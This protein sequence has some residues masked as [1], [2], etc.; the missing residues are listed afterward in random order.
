VVDL[1]EA[2]VRSANTAFAELILITGTEP[3][4]IETGSQTSVPALLDAII[5]RVP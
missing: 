4:L 1:R 5:E 2:L 3:V